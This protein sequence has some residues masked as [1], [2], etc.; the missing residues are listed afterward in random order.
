[1]AKDRWPPPLD[2]M[3]GSEALGWDAI[4]EETRSRTW[5]V[6]TLDAASPAVLQ[7]PW[8]VD[9]KDVTEFGAFPLSDE[10][11]VVLCEA[12]RKPVLREAYA[13]HQRT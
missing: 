7:P 11:A 4:V 13:Y 6:L 12:C 5:I 2:D 8:E 3:A 1:M 9:E 10:L